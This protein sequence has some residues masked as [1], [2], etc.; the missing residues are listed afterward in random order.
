MRDVNNGWLIRYTHGAPCD[1]IFEQTDF[2]EKRICL[3]S[4]IPGNLR[5][6]LGSEQSIELFTSAV[7]PAV[8]IRGGAL[9]GKVDK[10]DTSNRA[11][12]H[13]TVLSRIC[14]LLSILPFLMHV[15]KLVLNGIVGIHI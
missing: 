11:Q 15:V 3:L 1:G 2:V 9:Q 10:L 8:S 7:G 14:R 6:Y 5:N 13:L 12:Y 4:I